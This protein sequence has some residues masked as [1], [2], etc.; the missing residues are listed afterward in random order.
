[1]RETGALHPTQPEEPSPEGW[2]VG[3][4]N[5]HHAWNHKRPWTSPLPDQ[6]LLFVSA[7][8]R[9]PLMPGSSHSLSW[10]AETQAS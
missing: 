4:K 10:E 9:A 3:A 2:S 1:M 6:V 7:R 5:P 8:W